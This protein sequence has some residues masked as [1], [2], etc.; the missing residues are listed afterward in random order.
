MLQI[1]IEGLSA[2]RVY[3]KLEKELDSSCT[4]PFRVGTQGILHH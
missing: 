1:A 2:T 3:I 4:D